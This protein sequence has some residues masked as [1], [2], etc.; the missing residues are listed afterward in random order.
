MGARD[1]RD[2]TPLLAVEKGGTVGGGGYDIGFS[3]SSS[4]GASQ[5]GAT[6][7]KGG[8]N[9]GGQNYGPGSLI[10]L[11]GGG[12]ALAT[13]GTSLLTIAGLLGAGVLVIFWILKR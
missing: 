3:G 1:W 8:G 6:S 10:Q 12:G 2:R 5:S 4:S 13:P 11:A 9:Y 7:S